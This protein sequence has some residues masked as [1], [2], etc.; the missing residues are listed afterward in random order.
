MR[1]SS[2]SRRQPSPVRDGKAQHA[3]DVTFV[4]ANASITAHAVTPAPVP[5]QSTDVTGS[6]PLPSGS[7]TP[8]SAF[9]NSTASRNTSSVGLSRL[10]LSS[11]GSRSHTTRRPSMVLPAV[12][13]PRDLHWSSAMQQLANNSTKLVRRCLRTG[14][15]PLTTDMLL[16]GQ[17]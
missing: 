6:W 12:R 7:V 17:T 11:A 13:P 1:S 14:F 16:S 15:V 8:V 2:P 4:T 9:S 5:P 3:A 10:A